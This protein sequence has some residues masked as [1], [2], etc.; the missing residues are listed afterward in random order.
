MFKI[1]STLYHTFENIYDKYSSLLFG[2]AIDNSASTNQAEEILIITFKK[3]NSG[4]YINQ[5]SPSVCITLI[6]LLI[7]TLHE[8]IIQHENNRDFKIKQFENSPLLNKFMCEQINLNDYCIQKNITRAEAR[9]MLHDEFKK[10]RNNYSV[11][12]QADNT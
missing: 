2:I 1:E 5:T 8:E 3:F 12:S 10:I 4:G 11:L 9:K 7:Q 6:K